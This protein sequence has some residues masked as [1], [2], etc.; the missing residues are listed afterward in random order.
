MYVLPIG[1]IKFPLSNFRQIFLTYQW[2]YLASNLLMKSLTVRLRLLDRLQFNIFMVPLHKC[3]TPLTA[4]NF[5][6][7]FSFTCSQCSNSV[8]RFI[9]IFCVVSSKR[10]RTKA[11]QVRPKSAC[12][13]HR[14]QS[15]GW[16]V[17]ISPL[18]C[19]KVLWIVPVIRSPIHRTHIHIPLSMHRI[20]VGHTRVR[21]KRKKKKWK[22]KKE[23]I[24]MCLKGFMLF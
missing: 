8:V 4:Y 3:V 16:L 23:R 22:R 11:K 21:W 1:R 15:F 9:Y 12:S 17:F 5:T 20:M 10:K 18:H 19:P 2:A 7:F 13:T 14:R 24:E 6:V